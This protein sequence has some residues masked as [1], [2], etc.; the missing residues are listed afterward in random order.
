MKTL[1]ILKNTHFIIFIIQ[2]HTD[3]SQQ[4]EYICKAGGLTSEVFNNPSSAV[5][6]L[7]QQFFNNNTRFSGHLIMGY[8]KVEINE[9]PIADVTFRPF[10]CFIRKFCYSYIELV[11]LLKNNYAMQVQV[12]SLCLCIQLE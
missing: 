10:C 1:V 3:S 8:D 6:I 2:D 11:Y 4:P 7:Y 5:T 12:S 9:Q